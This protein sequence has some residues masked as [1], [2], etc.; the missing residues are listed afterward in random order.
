LQRAVALSDFANAVASVAQ[1]ERG[2]LRTPFINVD[3]TLHFSRRPV[4]EWFCV[5]EESVEAEG[6]VSVASC[7]L[8]DERGRCGRVLQSR[9]ANRMR[10]QAG[11]QKTPAG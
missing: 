11:E 10:R 5:R 4:G 9:L 2:A 3:T 8:Y 6:G 1:R 7:G